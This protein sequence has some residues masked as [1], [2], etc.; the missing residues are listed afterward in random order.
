MNTEELKPYIKLADL[1]FSGLTDNEI[2][3]IT[4]EY[5]STAE[6]VHACRKEHGVLWKPN[7]IW[8]FRHRAK[9]LRQFLENGFVRKCKLVEDPLNKEKEIRIW[10]NKEHILDTL[11]LNS[12]ANRLKERLKINKLYDNDFTEM[13]IIH[14]AM[15]S[16]LSEPDETLF[17]QQE[18]WDLFNAIR[19]IQ[20]NDCWYSYWDSLESMDSIVKKYLDNV[21]VND[22]REHI[23]KNRKRLLLSL[24]S[25]Y[26]EM[27]DFAKLKRYFN[28]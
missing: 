1:Y 27:C 24:N 15:S 11:Y 3:S 28:A 13:F 26:M 16:T 21:F 2:V 6:E 10:K 5:G 23:S 4:K 18:E 17:E 14:E 8:L 22:E 20:F 25:M 19:K 7:S 12:A 9:V